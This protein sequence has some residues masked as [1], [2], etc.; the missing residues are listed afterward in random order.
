MLKMSQPRPLFHLFSSL[1]THL[2]IF[3]TN[4]YKKSIHY[5]VHGFKLTALERESPPITTRPYLVNVYSI[6]VLWF[7]RV[8]F[9][10]ADILNE[11]S[12][13]L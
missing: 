6:E 7:A 10:L 5:T 2:T 11:K 1:Q 4:K 12:Q 9:H 13:N 3:T 8:L